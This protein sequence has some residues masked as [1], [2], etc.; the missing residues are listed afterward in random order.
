MGLIDSFK[1]NLEDVSGKVSKKINTDGKLKE[2]LEKINIS[3]ITNKISGEKF[4]QITEKFKGKLS[5][6]LTK[7]LNNIQKKLGVDLTSFLGEDVM[8][9]WSNFIE[10]DLK[11]LE[12][13]YNKL[14]IPTVNSDDFEKEFYDNISTLYGEEKTSLQSGY[15]YNDDDDDDDSYT[16]TSSSSFSSG[17][18]SSSSRSSSYYSSSTKSSSSSSLKQAKKEKPVNSR[19]I[20]AKKDVEIAKKQVEQ[21]RQWLAQARERLAQARKSPNWKKMS[22]NCGYPGKKGSFTSVECDVFRAQNDLEQAR[23]SLDAARLKV[24]QAKNY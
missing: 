13:S 17:S 6:T 4:S 12:D 19:L 10:D 7:T 15:S 24:Q 2:N 3:G 14:G 21:R 5:E 11:R 1:K 20:S 16:S 23:R 22:R 18:S 9:K 8:K